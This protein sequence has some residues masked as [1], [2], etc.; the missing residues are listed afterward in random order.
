MIK[1][2][3]HCYLFTERWSDEQIG[4]LD[5]IHN[6]DLDGFEIATGDDVLFDAALTRNKAQRLGL[7]LTI[8]PGGLWPHEC[9]LS[10]ADAGNRALG[11]KWHCRQVETGAALGATAYTGAL[12]GHPGVLHN[13]LLT[14]SEHNVLAEGLW[15]LA[16]YGQRNGVQ[17]VIEP[18]SHFRTHVINTSAQAVDMVTM[19]NHPNLSLLLDTYHLVTEVRDYGEQI[20]LARDYLWG[21][22]A[23]ENDRGVPGGG[24]VPWH[25]VFAALHD[26]HFNGHIV[27]ESYNSSIGL[28]PGAF[29]FSR[30][31]LHDVC[32]DGS[33]FVR[34]G[35]SFM[36]AGIG[37]DGAT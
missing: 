14:E 6:Q 2:S 16:E 26:I 28:T 29:A 15:Q 18:M 7:E 19:V 17:I 12:Y 10:N 36:R 31:M 35:L 13:R 34:K 9:D 21:L 8:S 37:A 5:I 24:I 22:H 11:L 30:G 33:E 27:F 4:L 25:E 32:H 1:Y 23:C 20:R 3:A